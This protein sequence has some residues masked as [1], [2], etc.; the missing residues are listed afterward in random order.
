MDF[1][2]KKRLF[3]VVGAS[4]VT[5][6]GLTL[7]SAASATLAHKANAAPCMA[8]IGGTGSTHCIGA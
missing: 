3:W 4:V 2:D 7:G 5:A 6:L 1:V 8:P